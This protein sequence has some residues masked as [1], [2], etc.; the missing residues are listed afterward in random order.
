MTSDTFAMSAPPSSVNPS[1]ADALIERLKTRVQNLVRSGIRVE[2][3]LPGLHLSY[4]EKNPNIASTPA[5][6]GKY[7]K[8]SFNTFV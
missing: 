8:P 1:A 7:V 2:S 3:H 5:F 4:I 6:F